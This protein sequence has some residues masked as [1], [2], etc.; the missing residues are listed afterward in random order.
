M[1]SLNGAIAPQVIDSPSAWLRLGVAAALSTIGGVGMWS[2][3]VALPAIQAEFGVSRERV[4]QRSR[5]AR[6]DER[7]HPAQLLARDLGPA[8]IGP[9]GPTGTFSNDA[10]HVGP[11]VDRHDAENAP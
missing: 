8:G 6:E 11:P 1:T 2:I 7:R 10:G 3:M 4:R 9:D 5:L